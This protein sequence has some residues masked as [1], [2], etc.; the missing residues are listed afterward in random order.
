MATTST[1]KW[2]LVGEDRTRG[3][4]KSAASGL[5]TLAEKS[6]NVGKS[7]SLYVTAPLGLVAAAGVKTAA[8]FDTTMATMRVN[9][10]ASAAEMDKLR[11][12]AIKLGADTVFSAGESAE[13]MLELSKAGLSVGEIGTASVGALKSTMDL[14]AADGLEL[15][16]A[17][18]I[19]ANA[20]A[21]YGIEAEDASK[22]T[23]ILAA[24]AV[25][26]TT[27]VTGLAA[28]LKYVGS[29]AA[30]L[31]VPLD[32][33]VTA[34]AALNNA[35][36]DASTAGTSLNQF[37]LGLIPTT[38][39]AKD[40][41][42]KYGLEFT[43]ASGELRPMGEIVTEL[44]DKL[45]GLTD[46][47]RKKVLQTIFNV[48]GMRTANVLL[49]EGAQG[50]EDLSTEVNKAGVDTDLANAR[51]EGMAGAIEQMKGS[52][53]TAELVIGTALTPIVEDLAGK[54]QGLANWFT[55]L[56][57]GTQQNVVRA[58]MFAAAMGPA[59]IVVGK[60]IQ[61]VK[62]LVG[63][64]QSLHRVWKVTRAVA[65]VYALSMAGTTKAIALS[66][67]AHIKHAAVVVGS[68][69]KSV[70]LSTA[71]L[72]KNGAMWVA[73]AAKMLAYKAVSVAVS[74]ATKA[75]AAA[76]WL[77]NVALNANPI[78][79]VIAGLA[80]LGG[81]LVLAWKKSETFRKVVTKGFQII[82]KGAL[83]LVKL[84]ITGYQLMTNAFLA[85]VSTVIR[86]AAKA[87]GWIPGIGPKL[88]GAADSFDRFRERVDGQFNK[89]KETVDKFQE[90]VDGLDGKKAKVSVDVKIQKISIAQ[91]VRNKLN[92]NASLV[93]GGMGSEGY[94]PQGLMSAT[95]GVGH[96]GAGFAQWG[97]MWSWN[98][99]PYSGM[100]QHDG[101]DI[102]VGEGT[103]VWAPTSGRFLGRLT[104]SWHGNAVQWLVNGTKLTYAH[105]SKFGGST[106]G[107]VIGY[108]GSTGNSSGPHLH[109]QASRNGSYVNPAL[110][111]A[112]GGIVRRRPG[113]TLAVIGEG[114]HD[115]A[116]VPLKPGMG[117]GGITININGGFASADEIARTTYKALRD[118]ER[119]TGRRILAGA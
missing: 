12:T 22:V 24:G 8:E 49:A 56:D 19:M 20:M 72:V 71:A 73:T 74:V 80:L 33:S 99:N 46:V 75:M 97:P 111:L 58:G 5:D 25:A 108:V 94:T 93:Y 118:Y 44:G 114:R 11:E 113:G 43:T 13:A 45:D 116:V 21:A 68:T 87:F 1:L 61:G 2:V 83:A 26:S 54:V 115:E 40:A 64:I 9:S 119:N 34:L 65:R 84:W 6:V 100:G 7:L 23:S 28:G 55:E 59:L 57:E 103:P 50:W 27:D 4:F 92:A 47:E 95:R 10:A 77:L 91:G 90:K 66:T 70:A 62:A 67:A 89:A 30:S 36:I 60:T 48:R 37:M 78:G 117:M 29:T 98:R 35:G 32:D 106:P 86:G 102:S 38:D 18:T 85:L 112:D 76:Q 81:A 42:K 14:A 17:A 53:E 104:G 88:K 79:L 51:M 82:A 39:K 31:K 63:G 96:P 107:G 105:L 15:A 3:A 52:L 16:D 41:I 110:Y 101:A 109:I 69:V